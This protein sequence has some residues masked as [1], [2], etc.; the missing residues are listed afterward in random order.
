MVQGQRQGRSRPVTQATFRTTPIQPMTTIAVSRHEMACDSRSSYDDGDFFA[1]DDKI[2]RIGDELV[3]CAGK[4]GDIFKFLAWYK[5]QSGERPDLTDS[6]FTAVVLNRRG[7]FVYDGTTYP[8]RIAQS[9][10]TIGS[11]SKAAKA[12]MLCG[13]T[14]AEAIAI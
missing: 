2:E 11:G 13:K 14:P 8:S 5:N 4:Y 1:C 3:G 10:F 12:A 6:D 7:I 9:F